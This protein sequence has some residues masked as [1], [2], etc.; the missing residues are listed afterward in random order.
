MTPKLISDQKK[1]ALHE[2]IAILSPI[3]QASSDDILVGKSDLMVIVPISGT[4]HIHQKTIENRRW[5]A[6]VLYVPVDR[7]ARKAGINPANST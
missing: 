3:P 6:S 7:A 4:I 1:I 5:W 2:M